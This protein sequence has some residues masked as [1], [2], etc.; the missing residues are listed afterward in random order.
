LICFFVVA[1]F[2]ILRGVVAIYPLLPP[3]CGSLGKFAKKPFGNITGTNKYADCKYLYI[4]G[5]QSWPDNAYK[6]AYHTYSDDLNMAK[7][8]ESITSNGV[9]RMADDDYRETRA[10]MIASELIQAMNRV[11]C[12]QWA[13]GDTLETEIFMLARDGDIIDL[14]VKS[15]P[16]AKVDDGFDFYEKLTAE[17]KERKPVRAIDAVLIILKYHEMLFPG[18]KKVKK[19]DIFDKYDFTDTLAKRTRTKIWGHPAIRQLVSDEEIKLHNHYVEF[20]E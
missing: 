14:I 4:A 5:V 16:G 13:N 18:M 10:S 19:K 17:I 6:I 15:M 20:L 7:P 8:Q 9:R 11:R 12:R 1:L 3:F 2:L